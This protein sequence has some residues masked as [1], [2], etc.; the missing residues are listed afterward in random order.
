MRRL[1]ILLVVAGIF[2][3][4]GLLMILSM[5][6]DVET[7]ITVKSKKSVGAK[8][9]AFPFYRQDDPRWGNDILGSGPHTLEQW[10]CLVTSVAMLFNG[11]GV[12]LDKQ[13]ADPHYMN[14]W[15]KQNNG[16]DGQNYLFE[17]VEK[18][19][20]KYLGNFNKADGLKD[21]LDDITKGVILHVKQGHH[22]VLATGYDQNGVFVN[23]PYY[24]VTQ[25]KWEEVWDTCHYKMPGNTMLR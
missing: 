17:S 19:G 5:R 3:I 22:F 12:Q 10:G 20:L 13:T 18:L 23:D 6:T 7:D 2:L 8:R 21:A 24:N 9:P 25:Y 1:Q 11:Y 16:F 15:L 4:V 14:L